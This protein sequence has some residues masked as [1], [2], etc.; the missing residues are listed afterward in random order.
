MATVFW[1]AKGII[2]ID[3]LKKNKTITGA[4]YAEL[5]DRFDADLKEKRP[6]L[7]RKKILFHQDNAPS[8]KSAV[9]MAKLHQLSYELIRFGS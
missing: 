8:H 5:L 6:G 1:D 3:Y 2:H 4:Y 7:A 9:A